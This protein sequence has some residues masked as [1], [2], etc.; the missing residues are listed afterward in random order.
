MKVDNY[1]GNKNKKSSQ[2][3]GFFGSDGH[4]TLLIYQRKQNFC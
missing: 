3:T 4:G 2:M 1:K